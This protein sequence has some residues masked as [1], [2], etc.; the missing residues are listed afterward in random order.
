MAVLGSGVGD[1]SPAQGA[2]LNERETIDRGWFYVLEPDDGRWAP[3]DKRIVA[4]DG[5]VLTRALHGTPGRIEVVDATPEGVH[6][7]TR[8]RAARALGAAFEARATAAAAAGADV[9]ARAILR[10]DMVLVLGPAGT[11]ARVDTW[12]DGRTAV[13][14]DGLAVAESPSHHPIET[15]VAEVLDHETPGRRRV[16]PGPL[17]ERPA[18]RAMFFESLMNTDMP[19][20]DKEI[21]QGVLHM[22]SPLRDSGTEVVLVNAKMPIVGDDRPVEGLERLEGALADGP[23]HLVG[24]TLLEGYWDGVG[25][26][27]AT[28]R[29]LG[30]RA[31]I[32]VGGVMPSLAPDHVAAHLD[33]VSFV[34][35]GAGEVFVPRL[36]QIVG[37]STVDEP[38]TEA[39]RAALLAMDGMY[40]H[41]RAGRRLLSCRSDQTV[42]VADLD[43]V[44]LDLSHVTA[45]HIEGGIELSTSRGCIYRCSF[46]SILGRESYQA[47]S[48]GSI[49]DVLET[50]EARFRELHGDRIPDNAYRVHISDDDFAC[51]RDRAAAFFTGLQ[52]TPFR[53][54]SVQVAVGD[55]CKRD[56]GVLLAEPDDELLDTM[57]ATCFADHG[58]PIPKQDFFADHKSRTWSSFL[59]IGVETYDDREIARLGKGYKRI[60]IRTVVA[61]LSRRGLH[62]D[63]YFILSNVDTS[64]EDL[65]AV[66][67]EVSR[68]KLRFPEHFHMRFPVVQHL[69]SY[70]TSASHRRH[71]RRGR[72]QQMVMRG[73]AAVPH[74]TELDYPFVDH[75]VP[76]DDWVERTVARPFVTDAG[77]YTGN[78]TALTALWRQWLADETDPARVARMRRLVRILDDRPRRLAFDLLRQ[79][80]V[81]GD[82]PDWPRAVLDRDLAFEAAVRVLGDPS[83]WGPTLRSAW[84]LADA[85]RRLV[86]ELADDDA[87]WRDEAI[88]CLMASDQ[89]AV[90]LHLLPTGPVQV[91]TILDGV[92]HARTLADRKDP[93]GGPKDLTVVVDASGWTATDAEAQT[94]ADLGVE[95]QAVVRLPDVALPDLGALRAAGVVTRAIVQVPTAATGALADAIATLSSAVDR[96]AIE[97][98]PEGW[99]EADA[100]A[101]GQALYAAAPHLGPA[102]TTL[103]VGPR[104]GHLLDVLAAADGT[105]GR[106][107]GFVPGTGL[108]ASHRLGHLED[109]T[110]VDR[111]AMDVLDPQRLPGV[112][113]H[114]A[115]VQ[116]AAKAQAVLA[117]FVAW[118][119]RQVES[120]EGVGARA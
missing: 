115:V 81:G 66:F 28:L 85:P 26:L 93:A 72:R 69:V 8:V 4:S 29:E 82:D 100:T 37:T 92:R 71:V 76:Q 33:E 65:V 117:R 27:I 53:L 103:E 56:N 9:E 91:A 94:L 23:I 86:V 57:P 101:L 67:T 106:S 45:R 95:V 105:L 88:A 62:M 59:Q 98:L 3:E 107:D 18:P 40:V 119:R 34:C 97:P 80:T 43:R 49:F 15:L 41:D 58:R 114:E 39:Q 20:N 77:L 112:A 16:P 120:G 83:A 19:H 74:H 104:S 79:A 47:R 118:T 22:I 102:G 50:Y 84:Q 51:D 21:S 48:A 96:L 109:L 54:S 99:D 32:A 2:T 70:F 36:A 111:H 108:S 42:Q 6:P 11:E 52:D 44:P 38:F 25:K 60:H 61:E 17:P 116:R 64:P 13:H 75:D 1:R 30:C 14:L 110:N 5:Q 7:A 78:L 24:I 10:A 55:L 90:V 68:L 113:R 73:H 35:R 46:C 31:H 87:T 63:G 12:D 89:P